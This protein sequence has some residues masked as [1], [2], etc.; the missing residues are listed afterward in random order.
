MTYGLIA[1]LWILIASGIP[2]LAVSGNRIEPGDV[3]VAEAEWFLV[4]SSSC[5]LYLLIVKSLINVHRSEEATR[6][7]DRAIASS[8][9]AIV[10]TDSTNPDDLIVYVNAAFERITGY[11]A[12]E[13][14]GQNCRLLLRDDRDQPEL[15]AIRAALREQRECHVVLRNYRKDGSLFWNDVYLAPVRD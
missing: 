14:I 13:V 8:S 12:A 15:E 10:I 2:F 5:L 3:L 11:A 7:R 6:L 1:A 4:A 9:N